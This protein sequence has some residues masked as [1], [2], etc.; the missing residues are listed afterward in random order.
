MAAGAWASASYQ[1]RR[2]YVRVWEGTGCVE[3]MPGTVD[4]GQPPSELAQPN[5][6]VPKSGNGGV[7][8]FKFPPAGQAADCVM[9][10]VQILLIPWRRCAELQ[11]HTSWEPVHQRLQQHGGF[12]MHRICARCPC[13]DR[14]LDG[15][16]TRC[17]YGGRFFIFIHVEFSKKNQKLYT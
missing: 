9:V 2:R 6:R 3:P 14:N 13:L 4:L 8:T 12:R 17:P 15:T 11:R 16:R 1:Q 5:A 10:A 7:A